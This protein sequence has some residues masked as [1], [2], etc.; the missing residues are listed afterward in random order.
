[1]LGGVAASGLVL[2]EHHRNGLEDATERIENDAQHLEC[3]DSEQWLI[4]WLPENNRRVAI[5]LRR[6][7]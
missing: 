6:R 1:M 5:A 4:T 2:R 7:A 3:N